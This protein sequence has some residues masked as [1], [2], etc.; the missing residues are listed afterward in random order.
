MNDT[1]KID[2]HNTASSD[3]AIAIIETSV[4]T[5]IANPS[6]A[7]SLPAIMLRGAPGVGK[8]TIVK[9]IA[10]RLGIGFIDVRLAQLERVDF[11]GLPSVDDHVTEWNVPAFWPRDKKSKGIIL[12]DEITSAP[13]DLQ[14]AAYQLVL[15]RRI[16]NSN[17]ELPDG[18]Y[19][20]AAGNRVT[21]RAVVKTMSSALANR[22][23][24]FEV[25]PNAEDWR[26]WA[27][28]HDI[29][30]SVTG[31]IQFRPG[32]LHKMDNQNLEQGWPSPRSWEKVS[33]VLAMFDRE[34]NEEILRKVVYGLIGPNVGVEFIE[35][36]RTAKK[37]GNVLDMLTNP[38]TKIEI[39]TK[40]DEK[41]AFAAAVNYLLWNGKSEKDDK[42]R[43]EGMY[44][45]LN[46][47]TADFAVMIVKCAMQGNT[48]VSKLQAIK[49]IMSSPSYK[50]FAKK[51]AKAF[52]EKL[53]LDK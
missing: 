12:L 44:R 13:A 1:T 50:E 37:F 3:E 5:L 28:K 48:R 27:V 8:S 26:G 49:L 19:I 38:K 40:S 53:S 36:H 42:V 46:A 52:A 51:H 47:L 43:V 24:H 4:K 39:P 16:S 9:D 6:L 14:V 17:Y 7:H 41:C 45:I 31:F 33:N 32:L 2:L 10:D 22:F 25:E 11:C 15:D 18:W 29:N 30:P 34:G 20:I 23:M 21:D 35:F